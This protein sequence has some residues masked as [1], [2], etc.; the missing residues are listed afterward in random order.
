M[1]WARLN[2]IQMKYRWPCFGDSVSETI[3][4]VNAPRQTKFC[5]GFT[6]QDASDSLF[7]SK[8]YLHPWYLSASSCHRQQPSG[9][10]FSGF[11]C[12][13]FLDHKFVYCQP[14]PRCFCN[15]PNQFKLAGATSRPPFAQYW[16]QHVSEKWSQSAHQTY[17]DVYTAI[18]SQFVGEFLT[19]LWNYDVRRRRDLPCWTCVC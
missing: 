9:L 17:R 11:H 13:S 1:E 3:K 19:F 16:F 18:F 4:T 15:Y 10:A 5:Q 8:L 7:P 6:L 2:P 14:G 12:Q